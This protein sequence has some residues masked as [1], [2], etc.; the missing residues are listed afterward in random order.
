MQPHTLLLALA[1]AATPAW[2]AD[3]ERARSARERG[4]TLPLAALLAAIE[5]DL[6]GRMIDVELED[7]GGRLVYEINLLLGDGRVIEL[8]VDA[9]TGHWLK[10]EGARLETLFPRRASAPSK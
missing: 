8:E 1:L 2:T 7:D 9:R 5:R 10:L 6:G 3:Q 4:T